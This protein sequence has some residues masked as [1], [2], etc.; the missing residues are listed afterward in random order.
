MLVN[1]AGIGIESKKMIEISTRDW[2]YVDVNLKDAFL[3]TREALNHMFHN[4]DI[5]DSNAKKI[6]VPDATT[7]VSELMTDCQY[8]CEL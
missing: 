7:N 3:W 6:L 5:P 1:N 4:S 8:T 2:S